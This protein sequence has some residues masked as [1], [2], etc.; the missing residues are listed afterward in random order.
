MAEPTAKQEVECP[1]CA[2]LEARVAALE[3]Q[4]AKAQ[5][6]SGNSSKP[7]S[8]DIVKPPKKQQ[9]PGRPKKRKIGGQPGHQRHL[10]TPFSPEELD[11]HWVWAHDECPC[12]GGRLV[13]ADEPPHILQQVELRELPVR[14]EQ[15]D[16]QPQWCARCEKTFVPTFPEELAKAGLVGPRL[17]A[18]VGFLKGACH[19]SFS[20]IRK[21][22]RD[23]IGVPISRGM[24]GKLVGKVSASLADPYEAL[25]AMLPGEDRLNVD[26]TGHKEN[27]KRLWTWCFRAYLYTVYKI[28]PSRG[29][30]VLIEVLGKEFDGILGCDYFSAYRKYMK[31][32]ENVL[33]QFCLAHFIRDVKFLVEHP[34][35]AN[36]QYGKLL[37]SHLRKLFGVIH[38][39][40]QFA[41]EA[42]FRK[43]L[44]AVRNSLVSDSILE[45]PDTREAGNLADRFVD[46]YE[47]Y[48]RFITEPNVEPT[49][50]LA[51]QAIR[52]VAIHR[53]ITQGTRSE[54]GR[55]WCERIWTVIQ[56]CGQQRRSVFEFLCAAVT[57]HFRSAP[58]PSL[59][60]NSS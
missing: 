5:K 41:G 44:T 20:S 51:E 15:H 40:E 38:R 28:S 10:R 32:N 3:A 27:G 19:M 54:D 21:Y 58:A 34:N 23:V 29:S 55:R 1:R 14:I 12:C 50:N 36:V 13:E 26:E 8:S 46:H 22:F 39:R 33:L 49:N 52:F 43:T 4:L 53:R 42:S 16:S 59:A 31:L 11:R 25:V 18:L 30:D 57:A 47:S 56:T 60:P 7:P 9:K 45:L 6:H 37:L 17:T 48:F 2:A 24:L 35:S